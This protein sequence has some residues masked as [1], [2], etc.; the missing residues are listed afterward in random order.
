[1]P[2]QGEVVCTLRRLGALEVDAVAGQATVGAGVALSVLQQAAESA[3]WEY[4][5]DFASRASATVGGSVATNAGGIRML[6]YGDTRAQLL[7]VTAVLGTGQTVSHLG[8]LLKDNTGYHLPGLLCGS[9]G[10][11]GVLTAARV[12]LVRRAAEKVVALLGFAHPAGAIGAASALRR[13]LGSLSA[14][15]LFFEPGMTLVRRHRRP[16]AR[17]PARRGE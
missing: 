10:T 1:V 14:V 16:D 2:L 13:D 12:R 5:V 4:G 15:E 7:G 6:R 3:G 8:G 17:L 9:E 11:L